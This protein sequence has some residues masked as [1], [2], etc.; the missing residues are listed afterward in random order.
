ML[1]RIPAVLLVPLLLF[2]ACKKQV[3]TEKHHLDGNYWSVRQFAQDQ[4][5][6]FHNQPYTL[7]RIIV[8]NGKSDTSYV[9]AF[10]L[11]W[12]YVLKTFFESDISDQKYLDHYRFDT[13]DDNT[14]MSRTFY[15]EAIDDNLFTRKLQILVDPLNNRIR[16]IYIETRKKT[17][18]K[19]REEKLYY[20]PIKEI[21]I[22]IHEK[23]FM[24]D[25]KDSLIEYRFM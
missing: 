21:Q 9:S 17:R 20:A 13:F 23:S 2:T 16:N 3:K 10:D 25:P 5:N 11:D 24:S 22:Q 14:T 7:Q 1:N 6:T 12:G 18:W 19:E 4:F 15:Y 8:A